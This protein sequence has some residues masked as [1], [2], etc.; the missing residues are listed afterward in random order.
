MAII[1][2]EDLEAIQLDAINAFTN[3]YLNKEVYIKYPRGFKRPKWAL[4]LL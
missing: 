4:R 1:A 2:K 3:S